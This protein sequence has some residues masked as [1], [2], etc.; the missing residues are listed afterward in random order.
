ML[1]RKF[2]KQKVIGLVTPIK[3]LSVTRRWMFLSKKI[4][5]TLCLIWYPNAD[6]INQTFSPENDKIFDKFHQALW[7]IPCKSYGKWKVIF[8]YIY[9][10]DAYNYFISTS[11]IL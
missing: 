5:M 9:F 10:C 7:Q 1:K 2:R 4:L 8:M 3:A 11:Q 6:A